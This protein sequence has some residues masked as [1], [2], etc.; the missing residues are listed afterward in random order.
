MI[1]KVPPSKMFQILR[2]GSHNVLKTLKVG[3]R[4]LGFNGGK[5][6]HTPDQTLAQD[7]VD[8][9]P[10]DVMAIPHNSWQDDPTGIH[11]YKWGMS[12]MG[13][14]KSKIDWSK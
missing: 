9:Y 6:F 3:G 4:K 8:K 11:T 14:W 2:T 5:I 12:H 13:D 1:N 10:N 7:I